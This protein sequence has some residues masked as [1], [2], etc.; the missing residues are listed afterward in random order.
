MK[1]LS[2]AAT[3]YALKVKPTCKPSFL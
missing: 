3:G 1:P 2:L